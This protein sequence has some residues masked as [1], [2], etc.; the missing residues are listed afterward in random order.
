[1]EVL[2][3]ANPTLDYRAM[4]HQHALMGVNNA[5]QLLRVVALHEPRHLS[6][7]SD[8]NKVPDFPREA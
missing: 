3:A 8:I 4:M 7:I 5:L 1:M 2:F 6:Q